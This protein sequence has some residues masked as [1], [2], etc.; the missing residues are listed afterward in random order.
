VKDS[1]DHRQKP[2]RD[3][4]SAEAGNKEL[5]LQY[6]HEAARSQR[7]LVEVGSDL[8]GLIMDVFLTGSWSEAYEARSRALEAKAAEQRDAWLALSPSPEW[9]RHWEDMLDLLEEQGTLLQELSA[10][11]QAPGAELLRLARD[12]QARF[13][14]WQ[15]RVVDEV[16]A[17]RE[18]YRSNR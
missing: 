6:Q 5:R 7:T 17:A 12:L 16:A 15:R 18:K 13:V 2:P 8:A 9:V 1:L 4:G 11:R 10:L 3:G 14:A